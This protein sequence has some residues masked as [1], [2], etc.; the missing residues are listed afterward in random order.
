VTYGTMTE[1]PTLDRELM[2]EDVFKDLPPHLK[3]QRDQMKKLLE[4]R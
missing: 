2:F 3:K 1:G 4:Q